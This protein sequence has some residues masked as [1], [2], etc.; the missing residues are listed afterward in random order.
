[1]KP[2][3]LPEPPVSL[4]TSSVPSRND[5]VRLLPSI[6]AIPFAP[7]TMI[8]SGPPGNAATVAVIV[9]G[10]PFPSRTKAVT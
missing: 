9:P 8:C 5:T 2:D 3:P 1:M 7:I 4:T 6:R 10:A